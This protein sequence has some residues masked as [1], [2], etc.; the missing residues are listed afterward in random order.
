MHHSQIEVMGENIS[1]TSANH[2][3]SNAQI[4]VSDK[5]ILVNSYFAMNIQSGPREN[6]KWENIG[7]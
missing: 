5:T 7:G 6:Q 2:A 1:Q 3:V 4:S